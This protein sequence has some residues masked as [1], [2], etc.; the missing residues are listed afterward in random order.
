MMGRTKWA[1][2]V[3]FVAAGLLMPHLRSEEPD[4]AASPAASRA[5]ASVHVPSRRTAPQNLLDFDVYRQRVEPIFLVDRGGNG[6]GASACVTCHVQSGTP[7]RL[8]PLQ[9]DG[10]GGVYWTEEQSRMNFAVVS[11][12]VTPGDPQTSRLLR[13]PLAMSAGGSRMHVGGKFWDSQDD[14]EWQTMAEWVRAASPPAPTDQAERPPI[15]DFD[16]FETCIQR[17]FLD[18]EEGQHRMECTACHGSGPRGFAQ[19]LPEGRDFWNEE[20]SRENFGIIMEYVEPGDPLGSRFL[21]H[22]LAPEAGGDNY[23]SG[24]RRWHSQDDP[25]WQMLAAWVRGETPACAVQDR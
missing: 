2:P 13:E 22:P 16:F 5:A 10:S 18:R 19:T 7:M 20:E 23:H 25:E 3:A 21:T 12:L 11:R 14:P 15:P 17:I 4:T 24:G 1:A 9:E 8:Q 6:P